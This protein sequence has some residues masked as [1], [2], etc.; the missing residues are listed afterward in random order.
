MMNPVIKYVIVRFTTYIITLAIAVTIV[1]WMFHL[2][3]GDPLVLFFKSIIL[4]YG[5]QSIAYAHAINVYREA[6]GL[7]KPLLEQYI[8][9]LNELLKGNLG[10]S[11][12]G[13]PTPVQELLRR[14][15]PWTIGLLSITTLL[16][17]I[18][19]IVLGALVGWKQGTKFDKVISVLA[20]GMSQ[21]P[22]YIVAVLGALF[23]GYFLGLFPT[24]GG[25][26]LRVTPGF[27]FDFIISVIQH[28]T[29][30]AL[31]IVLTSMFG[32]VMSQRSLIISILG[33]DYLQF[34]E[35][36]GL[37]KSRIFFTYTMRNS[38]LPQITALGIGL[39]F[40]LSG[41][42]IVEHIFN[43]PGVGQLFSDA[44]HVLDYNTIMGFFILSIFA[45]LTANLIVD[46][47]LPLIDPRIRVGG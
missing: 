10:P 46:L 9:F 45:V 30:P 26:S 23:L 21:I 12:I 25:Y 28:G 18:M 20:M 17:W 47:L 39:G 11:L 44:Y 36:K 41:A 35:A 24:S 33:E 7:D 40:I 3:P 38:L 2:L 29:L 8:T 22:F 31:S 4:K 32:W 13:F 15:L 1:W 37:K 14:R 19:G 34:A 27:N 42:V 43:Y 16:A 5:S 6:F